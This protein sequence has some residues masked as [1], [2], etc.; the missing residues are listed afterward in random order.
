MV[1]KTR[2]Y[3]STESLKDRIKKEID[4]YQGYKGGVRNNTLIIFL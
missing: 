4:D 2:G 3:G 1:L